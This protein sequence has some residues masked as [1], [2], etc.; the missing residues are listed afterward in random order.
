MAPAF[1][2]SSTLCCSPLAE[3]ISTRTP[4]HAPP[5][6]PCDHLDPGHVGQ[7]QV[8]HDHVGPGGRGDPDRLPA[9]AGRGDHVVAGGGQ[10]AADA[11][12][13]HRV[14]VDHHH[15]ASALL[16]PSRI[17]APR[18]GHLHLGALARARR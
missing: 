14:V 15:P 8:E 2:A 18:D 16:T 4:G 1:T 3:S 10:V 6:S 7:L 9:L 17:S 11:L 13:P 12:A 5:R